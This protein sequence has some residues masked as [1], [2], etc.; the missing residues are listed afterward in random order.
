MAGPDP[1]THIFIPSPVLNLS[2]PGAPMRFIPPGGI[3]LLPCLYQYLYNS[4][5]EGAGAEK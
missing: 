1:A 4:M 3:S 2:C 5:N